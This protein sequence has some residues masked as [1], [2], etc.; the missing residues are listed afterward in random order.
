MSFSWRRVRTLV[1]AICTGALLL[2]VLPSSAAADTHAFDPVLSLTGGCTVDPVLDPVPDPGPCP[3]T[4]GPGGDHPKAPFANPRA[5]ATDSYGDIFVGMGSGSAGR[6]DIFGP[7][8][9]F[10]TE[11]TDEL[12]PGA[13]AI[14]SDGNL[15]V[16]NN[17]HTA[18]EHEDYARYEPTE[19]NPVEEKI[20]YE[21]APQLV[22][23]CG[24]C[25]G[26]GASLDVDRSLD[27]KDGGRL[28]LGLGAVVIGVFKPAAEGNELI[29]KISIPEGARSLSSFVVDSAHGRIYLA[30][31]HK[32]GPEITD[33]ESVIQAIELDPPHA[34]L[35]E[36]KG[37]AVPAGK[38]SISSV[39]VDEG[40]GH[41]FAYDAPAHKVYEFDEEGEYLK[42]IEHGFQEVFGARISVD[43]GVNSPNGA[44]NSIERYLFVPSHPA[45]IGHSF[46]FGPPN[47][48]PPKI[49]STSFSNVGE[50]EA[51]LE[52]LIEPFGLETHYTFEYLTQ[53]GY[54]EE[55]NSFT[56]AQLAGEGDIPAGNVPVDVAAIVEGLEPGTRYRFRVFAENAK[57][58][59]EAEDEFATFPAATPPPLCAN[60]SLRTGFSALLPDC[61]AY[62]LVTPA[63]TNGHPIIGLPRSAGGLSFPTRGAS[64]TGGALSFLV[65]GGAIPGYEGTG[66]LRGDPYLATRGSTGWQTVAAG[67]NSVESDRLLQPGSVSPDQ[68][69]SFWGDTSGSKVTVPGQNN[70]LRYPNGDS[71][72]IGRGSLGQDPTAAGELISENGGHVLFTSSA[73]LEESAPPAGTQALY[74][75]TI[76]S[77]TAAEQTHVVSLLPGD[78][79]PEAGKTAFYIGASLDGRGVAFRIGNAFYLR[80]ENEETYELGENIA[81]AGIAEGGARAFYLEGGKLWRFDATSKERTEFSS[82]PVTPVNVAADGNVAYFVSQSALTGEPNPNGQV[83]QGGEKNLYRSEEGA[84]SFVGAVTERD[85]EGESSNFPFDGLGTWIYAVQN[86]RPATEASRTTPDGQ[87]LL[88][89]ARA[90]LDGYDPQGQS[91][92]YRYDFVAN[93]LDCLSCNPTLAPAT[94]D[95]TLVSVSQ[96]WG[97]DS[98]PVQSFA[99]LRNL[100][101]D[102]E[103]AF[104]QSSEALVPSDVDGL[105]DVYEW[106]AQGVGSCDR[107][108][109]CLYLISSGNSPGPDYLYAL[110]DS[111]DDAFI[112]TPDLLLPAQDPDETP[113]I[114]DARVG[115]GFPTNETEEECL[116]EACQPAAVPPPRSPLASSVFEGA[117]NVTPKKKRCRKSGSGVKRH[118]GRHRKH[119]RHHRKH[120]RHSTKRRAGR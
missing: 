89:Q 85:V 75:R 50:T 9:K 104:F 78:E 58:T 120:P 99:D 40:S 36:V 117:G 103:R 3:G 59:D 8:G 14:D 32:F 82:V 22:Y 84:I 18:E 109:G 52:T 17:E 118:C 15:Y 62:E 92:I 5:V 34:L 19:Y 47:E 77:A 83:A 29:E 61:R 10:I 54:E 4:L 13:L 33:T 102:G 70:F 94:S 23:D 119:H 20:A 98:L 26:G 88:F 81:F 113:S 90:P 60:D 69:Y 97:Q 56:G 65:E 49:E 42:T 116:G 11:I 12:N 107:A 100:R 41:V 91:E 39:A 72:P 74:D 114:Y 31:R 25:T 115:G 63:D 55:G 80:Y 48:G 43:N 28:F 46:A 6:I 57:G 79:T 106:E 108:G 27:P 24:G 86:G 112:F 1:P 95:A 93:E 87:V 111:G 35:F 101:A 38:F 67:P 110:S 7:T 30:D 37:T 45:G 66:S 16:G 21:K 105:Q 44:L 76:D 96:G 53:Q 73:H 51:E 2:T 68:R 71:E 64:P